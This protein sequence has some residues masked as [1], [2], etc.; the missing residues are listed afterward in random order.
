MLR[1]GVEV[2]YFCRCSKFLLSV[3]IRWLEQNLG[4]L[5]WCQGQSAGCWYTLRRRHDMRE[6][7]WLFGS[8][9]KTHGQAWG[10]VKAFIESLQRKPM[11]SYKQ[12][13]HSIRLVPIPPVANACVSVSFFRTIVDCK[14]GNQ[15]PQLGSSLPIVRVL[16][17]VS[18]HWITE[19]LCFLGGQD[20][21]RQFIFW[22]YVGILKSL[23][24]YAPQYIV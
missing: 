12:L 11:Q 1:D 10:P 21:S 2:T 17:V 20:A 9:H 5:V 14:K 13:L 15:T 23:A 22:E 6:W 3:S 4:M 24:S 7:L 8:W 18:N 16:F 19:I